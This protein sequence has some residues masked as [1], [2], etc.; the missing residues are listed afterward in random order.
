MAPPNL[1]S[2]R[3]FHASSMSSTAPTWK[4]VAPTN[5]TT[6]PATSASCANAVA[7]YATGSQ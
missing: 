4:S 7:G 6:P 5:A 3:S 2:A 1:V